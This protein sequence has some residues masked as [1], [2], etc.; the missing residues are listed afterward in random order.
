MI[1]A[2]AVVSRYIADNYATIGVAVHVIDSISKYDLFMLANPYFLVTKSL[3]PKNYS[4]TIEE[5][6]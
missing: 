2:R 1:G 4:A 5:P 6:F 3:G